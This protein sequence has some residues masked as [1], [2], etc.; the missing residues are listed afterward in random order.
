MSRPVV[1]AGRDEEI[2]GYMCFVETGR[3][4]RI[5]HFR[6]PIEDY[7]AGINRATQKLADLCAWDRGEI[8]LDEFLKKFLKKYGI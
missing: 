1:L 7:R 6:Q 8:T 3:G 4:K 2:D 5:I